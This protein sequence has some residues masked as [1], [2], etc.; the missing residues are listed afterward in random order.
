[1][2]I[3][4]TMVD[5]ETLATDLNA[6]ILSIAAVKFDPFDDY[7]KKGTKPGDLPTL[8]IL[9][10]IESQPNR[11]INE[12]TVD[13]WGKQSEPVRESIFG[14]NHPRYT[15]EE[16]LDQLHKFYWNSGGRIWAQGIQFDIAM[17]EHAYQT[18]N[19]TQPWLYW[20]VRD[21]RTLLDLVSVSLPPATHDAAEDCFRQIVGVQKALATL[22]VN[23][24][25]R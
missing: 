1:M 2:Q 16:A 24:F 11:T 23:K 7:L 5:I 19:R 6:V 4:D 21:S 12:N 14:V 25:I 3:L 13:W 17:L 22:G 10:D 20:Q 8:N 9:V 15:L 18:T